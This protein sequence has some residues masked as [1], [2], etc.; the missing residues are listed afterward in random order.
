LGPTGRGLT[1]GHPTWTPAKSVSI[2]GAVMRDFFARWAPPGSAE[3]A[4]VTCNAD[5]LPK[6]FPIC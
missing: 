3:P 1:Q 5:P 2:Y 4:A 6:L